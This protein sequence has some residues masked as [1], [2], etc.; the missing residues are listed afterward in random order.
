MKLNQ[1]RANELGDI[2]RDITIEMSAQTLAFCER[3]RLDSGQALDTILL[4]LLD[5]VVFL[6]LEAMFDNPADRRRAADALHHDVTRLLRNHA[7]HLQVQ[8][9]RNQYP[10]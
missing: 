1:P 3:H 9:I 6:L 5:G 7:I 4:T 10:T 2:A 8:K